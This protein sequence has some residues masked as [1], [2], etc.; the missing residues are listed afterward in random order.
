[1]IACRPLKRVHGLLDHARDAGAIGDAVG[2]GHRFAAGRLDLLHH[3][4]G[5]ARIA[6]IAAGDAAA[7]IVDDDLGAFLRRQQRAFLADAV[8][9]ARHQND[10]AF[11][12]AHGLNLPIELCRWNVE[13]RKA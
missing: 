11:H 12:H 1:M 6:P 9:A 2:I 5:R 8:C 3:L 4:L 13:R 10:L 7:Q